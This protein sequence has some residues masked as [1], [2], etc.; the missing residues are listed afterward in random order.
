MRI[1]VIAPQIAQES[2]SDLAKALG[3]DL[4]N[5]FREDRRDYR[6]YDLVFNYGCNRDIYAKKVINPSKAV[7]TCKNKV[8]TFKALQKAQVPTVQYATRK[9]DVQWAYSVCRESL[10]G[11]RG[12]GMDFGHIDALPDAALYTSYFEHKYEYRIVVFMGKV[13]GRYRKVVRKGM[14]ELRL[15]SPEGFEELDAGCIKA[16]KALGID[17]VG[18]DVLENKDGDCIILEANSAPILT[19]EAQEAIVNELNRKVG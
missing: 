5:P 3:A 19:Y 4:S 2:A 11:A 15:Y 13:V 9:E 12:E 6:K 17:Y 8:E 18:F 1:C 7:A 16:A 10:D 14:W